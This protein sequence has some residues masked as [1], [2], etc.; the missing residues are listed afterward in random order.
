VLAPTLPGHAGGAGLPEELD[1]EALL[2][3]VE[4]VLDD[5][6]FDRVHIAGHSLGGY[7]AL[8][9]AERGRAESVVALAPAGGWAAGDR[10]WVEVV[11]HQRELQAALVPLAPHAESFVA[12]PE[13]RRMVTEIVVESYEHIPAELL[14]HQLVGAAR[15]AAAP[16]V[17]LAL[18]EGWSL[19]AEAV[20]CP[21]RVVWGARDRVL[22]WPAAAARYREEWLPDADWVVLDGVG[23]A[24]Q[25][26]APLETAELIAG[27]TR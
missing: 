2:A 12:T 7:V 6:G 5:A 20:D 19:D 13:G 14:V 3:L 25:L 9:L 27:F 15:C 26:D 8:R 21:V 23:H 10:S 22:P 18:R 11:E 1:G 16:M 17:E 4:G 24:P